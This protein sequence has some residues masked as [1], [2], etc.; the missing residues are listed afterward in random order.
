MGAATGSTPPV[1]Y[2]LMDTMARGRLSVITA[3]PSYQFLCVGALAVRSEW[4]GKRTYYKGLTG[5]LRRDAV[6]GLVS[7]DLLF[8]CFPHR[9]VTKFVH[10]QNRA[11]SIAAQIASSASRLFIDA[12]TDPAR[13]PPILSHHSPFQL[14][15]TQP[16]RALIHP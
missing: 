3:C 6:V 12:P 10:L 1:P 15:K 7:V 9:V 11:A 13:F 8:L 4:S 2:A 5:T 16:N 14:I